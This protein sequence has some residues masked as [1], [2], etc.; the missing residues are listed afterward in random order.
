M[1]FMPFRPAEAPTVLVVDD[2]EQ[3]RTILSGIVGSLGY[4]VETAEDGREALAKLDTA[5][6]SAIVTDLM[7]PRMDGFEL[8]RTLVDRGQFA[9]AIVLTSFGDVGHAV[10]IV[11]DLQAF[12]FLEKPAQ[13]AVLAPLLDRAIKYGELL[14]GTARLQ[15]QLSQQGVLGEMIGASRAMQQVFGLIQRVAPTQASV[16]I[17]GESGTGKEM[18]ARAIHRLGPR[19][20]GPFVAVN[21]A[22]VPSELIESELFGHEK[23]SF[24]GAVGR[25]LGC[26]EQANRGTLF[27]DEIGEMPLGMQARLLRALEES[28]VRRVGG[29]DEI[30]VDVRILAATNRPVEGSLNDKVLREDLFYRLNVFNVHLPPLRQRKEDIGQL[31]KAII[32]LLN[33]K[34]NC[35]V[36]ALHRDS[37][38]KLMTHSWPGNVRELRNVLEWAV[39]TAHKDLILPQHLPKTLGNSATPAPVSPQPGDGALR[40]ELGRPLDD[41][42]REYITETLKSVNIDRQRAA[43]SLGISLRTL[44]NWLA[45]S[46]QSANVASPMSEHSVLILADGDAARRSLRRAALADPAQR[47]DDMLILEATSGTEALEL[48]ARH[49]PDAVMVDLDLPDLDGIEVHSRLKADA[50]FTSP[51]IVSIPAGASAARRAAGFL[52]GADAYIVEP[53]DPEAL[54]AIVRCTLRMALRIGCAERELAATSARLRGVQAEMEQFAS[55]VCHDV[56]EPLRAVTTFVQLVEE[57]GEPGFTASER[58]F[59][60]HVLVASNRVRGLLRGFLSYTQ[61]GRGRRAH[62]GRLDLGAPARAAVQSLRKRVEESGTSII[63]EEA[64]PVVW[65]DFGQLQ[66]VFEQVIGNAID[67]R[68]PGSPARIAISAA[69]SGE[70]WVVSVADSG[71]GIAPDFHSSV[72]LPVKRLHGR[73]NPGT[74]MGLAISKRIVEAHGGCMWVESTPGNGSTFHF[75]LRPLEAAEP[76]QESRS[77]GAGTI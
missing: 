8:L 41:I 57:R 62:F 67:Y 74:G 42:K 26:F 59:L 10:T 48:T 39:I 75:T 21:C 72:F 3:D 25:H 5:P 40:F 27:L 45:E 63:F 54:A 14:R 58:G 31:S 33:Q 18:V 13:S 23:G 69:L 70:T 51:V 56:E 49:Q 55:Q 36:T 7:M 24:T 50:K 76:S 12:W 73:D 35:T 34:H 17:T 68:Q 22:A 32:D 52:C 65:G 53:S 44:Y 43:Q 71:G 64:W 16:L 15:R 2:S 29:S 38:Q 19:S 37:L 6:I 66:Q 60:E 61:A 46:K 4:A 77:R 20:G 1:Q 11:H 28:K 30:P 47:E 9:P